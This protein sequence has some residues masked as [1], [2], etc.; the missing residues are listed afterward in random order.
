MAFL[1]F[2][3]EIFCIGVAGIDFAGMLPVHI[4]ELNLYEV[5]MVFSGIVQAEQIVNHLD[6]AVVRPSQVADAALSLLLHAP[7]EHTVVEE[8][9]VEGF[10]AVEVVA[11]QVA[12]R[13]AD[14]VKQIIVDMV[15]L[16]LLERIFE[17]GYA[18]FVAPGFGSKVREFC[19]YEVL[20]AVVACQS[21]SCGR[22]ALSFAVGG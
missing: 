20:G 17:H 18:G 1:E 16:Q 15:G 4:V 2:T 3:E 5:P 19:R 6:I 21:R 22:F 13:H 10:H 7:V 9:C 12:G 11:L 8:P 14:A